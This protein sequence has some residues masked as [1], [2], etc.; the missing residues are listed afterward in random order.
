MGYEVDFLPV[1]NGDK[2]GDAIAMRWGTPGNYKVLVYDGGTKESGEAMVAH[3][4]K[5]YQTSRVDYVINS[6]PDGDH[7][8]GLAVV[9]EELDV[10]ELWMH[11]PW[12]HSAIIRDYFK[13]GRITDESLA[14]RLKTKMQ[15]A[16]RLEEI[17]TEKGIPIYEPFQGDPIGP[18]WVL[19]PPENWYIH[20]LIP[21]FEKSPEQ[22]P[23][24]AMA[25]TIGGLLADAV[26]MAG[27]WL[28]ERWN[29]EL[30]REDVETSAENESSVILFADFDGHGVLLDRKSTRLNSSHRL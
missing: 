23:A 7:A 1:G 10:G 15:A 30:L 4:K 29:I 24:Q 3:V 17:A 12:E 14:E 2:S 11:R 6:H 28:S 19:S 9:L 8:S 25:K 5:H 21:A 13:D 16:Y 22:K 18:F 27:E 20:E 26:R